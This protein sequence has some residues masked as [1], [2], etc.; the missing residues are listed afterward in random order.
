MNWI[1][2]AL[3][4][5]CIDR[6]H[7]ESGTVDSPAV[8]T[9][10]STVETGPDTQAETGILPGP[11]EHVVILV[12]DG[13][14][15]DETIFD[16][17]SSASGD[18]TEKI[19][20][21]MRATL[22]PQGTLLRPAYSTGI[23]ETSEG[24]SQMIT[25]VRLPQCNFPSDL[26]TGWFLHESP[27][28]FEQFRSQ[29]ELA[30]DQAVLVANTPHLIP[31]V[32]SVWPGLGQ[33]QA[34]TF[35]ELEA[36]GADSL[37]LDMVLDK[38]EASDVRYLLANLH[39]IDWAGHNAKK[40]TDY[41]DAITAVDTDIIAVWDWIQ[42]NEPYAGKTL[43]VVTADHGRHR[44]EGN[45]EDWRNHGDQCAGCRQVLMFLAGPGIKADTVVT[46]RIWM[47]EDLTAT[48]SHLT[49]VENPLGTGLVIEDALVAPPGVLGNLGDAWPWASRTSKAWQRYTGLPGAL[50]QVLVDDQVLSSADA[51]Q[52][53]APRMVTDGTTA[54][55]CWREMTITP[56]TDQTYDDW[57]WTPRCST[58]KGTGAWQDMAFP[59]DVVW[60]FF[61]PSMQVDEEGRLW[62]SYV[63]NPNGS[64][65]T[66]V[67]A[68]VRLLR[69]TP[70]AGWEG[71][72]AAL[73]ARE[74]A[75]PIYSTL[76]LNGDVAFVSYT[77]SD[78]DLA[79]VDK[80][81][82]RYERH[83]DV[84]RVTWPT[85]AESTWERVLVTEV[86]DAG[87]GPASA[88]YAR[89]EHP[90][91]Y[92][93]TD[94]VV[95]LAAVAYGDSAG[96]TLIEYTSADG[97]D[98]WTGPTQLETTGKV[99]GYVAP[100]WSGPDELGWLLWLRKEGATVEVCRRYVTGDEAT[101]ED[102]GSAWV[103]GLTAA[104]G[105]ATVSTLVDGAWE[106][107]TLRF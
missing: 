104:S 65:D 26:G 7:G 30:P 16:G 102:T 25:G 17:T 19:L 63:W 61:E 81:Y 45:D 56:T 92:V 24:H 107:Q 43:L 36:G 66:A 40:S 72:D 87:H 64:G 49:G 70:G 83:L 3:A 28:L 48:I 88:E 95:H 67:P 42:S 46:D 105:G 75:Y 9:D 4:F 60:P 100:R 106:I 23:T 55:A 98:T 8:D 79:D 1:L 57:S 62:L 93:H 10:D 99:L 51:T 73:G 27:T 13:A 80:K 96:N 15:S 54:Y 103:Q 53:E 101:C 22:F 76:A 32:T 31:H 29:W 5:S 85:G 97:G 20:P 14:R 39:H 94:G 21:N 18:L 41:P 86:N 90:Q 52:A 77:T 35:V 69:Y 11:V 68:M 74:V 84:H 59:E 37:V 71:N 6:K 38:L 91:L 58:R 47:L 33:E 50:T 89:M 78:Y 44:I 82:A 34:G 2:L 12:M